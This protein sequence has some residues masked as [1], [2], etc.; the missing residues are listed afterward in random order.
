MVSPIFYVKGKMIMKPRKNG[1]IKIKGC[2][3]GCGGTVRDLSVHSFDKDQYAV[4]CSSCG[5]VGPS[6]QNADLALSGWNS[7]VVVL[8]PQEKYDALV[9]ESEDGQEES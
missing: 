5:T 7:R 1:K 9:K 8:L 3:F 6:A 4:A 2:P